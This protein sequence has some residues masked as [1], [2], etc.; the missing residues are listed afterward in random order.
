MEGIVNAEVGRWSSAFWKSA[1]R[2]C[3]FKLTALGG[4]SS[5]KYLHAIIVQ[6]AQ[7][8]KNGLPVTHVVLGIS[9]FLLSFHK[10]NILHCYTVNCGFSILVDATCQFYNTWRFTLHYSHV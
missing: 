9:K 1:K 3:R 8:K 4:K 6:V 7:R 5:K 10:I 2:Q